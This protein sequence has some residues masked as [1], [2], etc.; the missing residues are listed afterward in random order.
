[1]SYDELYQ[2]ISTACNFYIERNPEKKELIEELLMKIKEK[3]DIK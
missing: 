2:Y 3:Y 1:M